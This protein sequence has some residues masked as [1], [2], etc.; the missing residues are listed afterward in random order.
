[1]CKYLPRTTDYAL[2][3]VAELQMPWFKSKGSNPVMTV[4]NSYSYTEDIKY[5][6]RLLK[7]PLDYGSFKLVILVPTEKGTVCGLFQRLVENGVSSALQSIQ[8]LFTVISDLKS[9]NINFY[10]ENEFMLEKSE[11]EEPCQGLSIGSVNIHDEGVLLKCLT[12]IHSQG[13]SQ[14]DTQSCASFAH[15]QRFLFTI[16][17][18]DFAMFTGQYVSH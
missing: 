13:S 15:T 1:M 8:P 16:M 2:V 5:E 3:N 12:C 9:P 17:Y 11:K 4:Y 14:P 10:E 18:N 6:A 7:L